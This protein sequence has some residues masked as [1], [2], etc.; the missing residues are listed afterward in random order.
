MSLIRRIGAPFAVA[1]RGAARIVAEIGYA[2]A[3]L[4]RELLDRRL[5]LIDGHLRADIT[6]D[7]IVPMLVVD[8]D[9]AEAD[10]LLLTLD[11]LAVMAE[12]DQELTGDRAEQQ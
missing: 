9:E 6:P 3:L 12:A 7:A 2:D 5:I 8:L 1:D 10:K 4:A 11:P